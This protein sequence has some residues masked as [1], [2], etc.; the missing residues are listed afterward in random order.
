LL[1]CQEKPGRTFTLLEASDLCKAKKP[2]IY[3]AVHYAE[4]HGKE[5]ATCGAFH[6][7]RSSTTLSP[8][9]PVKNKTGAAPMNYQSQPR[10]RGDLQSINPHLVGGAARITHA[11]HG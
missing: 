1:E 8:A 10:Q 6:F 7:K 9:P 11:D 5:Y 2:S 3:A 4:Q